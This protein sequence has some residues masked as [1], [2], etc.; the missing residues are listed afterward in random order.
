MVLAKELTPA[1]LITAMEQGQFYASSGVSLDKVT[2]SANGLEVEVQASPNVTYAI[3]FIGTRKGYQRDSKPI[4]DRDGKPINATR[5]YSQDIGMLLKKSTGTMAAYE[6]KG[7]E[8]YVRARITSSKK[9]PNPS[10][11]GEFERA[12]TQPTQGPAAPKLD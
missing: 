9:H 11:I 2:S 5:R 7:D 10:E 6:F 12:W 3:E 1:A 4:L 8:L